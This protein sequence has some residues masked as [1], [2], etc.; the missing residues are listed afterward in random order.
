MP[1]VPETGARC[2]NSARRDLCGGPP[3]RAV[4]TVT[5]RLYKSRLVQLLKRINVYLIR[6]AMR[7]YKRLARRSNAWH[8]LSQVAE[9][10]PKLWAHW[11]AGI[12][13]SPSVR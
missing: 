12:W 7:K 2:G 10:E 11:T 4:P 1:F 6:W 3:A 5:G 8:Y 9:R 13:P